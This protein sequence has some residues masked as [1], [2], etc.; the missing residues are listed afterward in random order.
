MKSIRLGVMRN[1]VVGAAVILS[2]GLAEFSQA[3]EIPTSPRA[4]AA[5][6]KVEPTLARDLRVVGLQLGA[7]LFI[8][9]F[10]KSA[11]LEVWVEDR[12]GRYSLFRTYDICDY[13]GRLGPKIK[14]GDMQSPEGFYYVTAEQLNP[15]SYFHLS[16]NLGY[17]NA[18]DQGL[19]RTGGNLMIHGDCVSTGC[20]A[21][22]DDKIEEIY[23]LVESALRR[24]QRDFPVHVFPFRMTDRAMYRFRR[25]PWIDFWHN[26]K[27]GYDLFE[28]DRRPPFVA[29]TNDR[30]VFATP[31][32]VQIRIADDVEA[33]IAARMAA[34]LN[35]SAKG[36]SKRADIKPIR[37][38]EPVKASMGIQIPGE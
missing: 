15:Q 34:N 25:S 35:R 7:P 5:V 31:D 11:E 18:F 19:G 6:T 26:L 10:K 27:Q 20:Y 30:Y 24:G 4:R 13:S 38:V 12:T 2:F 22:T 36:K 8:R 21:M 28:Q 14:Q 23:T 1:W 17:P 33:R 37:D 29:V 16:F 3:F 32:D 9:V